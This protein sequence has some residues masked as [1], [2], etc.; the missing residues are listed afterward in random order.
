MSGRSPPA[1]RGQ[2]EEE[3]VHT[4]K[5]ALVWSMEAPAQ[6]YKA[7]NAFVLPST[8]NVLGWA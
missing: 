1:Y 8:H 6:T 3:L 2:V 5:T 7:T 4:F